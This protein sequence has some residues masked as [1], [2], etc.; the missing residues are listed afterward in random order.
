M[1]AFFVWTVIFW[2]LVIALIGHV[3]NEFSP[4]KMEEPVATDDSRD[5]FFFITHDG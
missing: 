2:V 5:Y 4:Q 3:I 1:F